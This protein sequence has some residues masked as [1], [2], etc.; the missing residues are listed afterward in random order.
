MRKA[1]I[2]RYELATPAEQTSHAAVLAAYQAVP[3][4]KP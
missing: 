4:K 3:V 1:V 2:G